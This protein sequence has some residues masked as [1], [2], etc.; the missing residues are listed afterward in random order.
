MGRITIADEKMM[1]LTRSPIENTKWRGGM[2]L[3][4]I[5]THNGEYYLIKIN[6]RIP[7]WVYLAVGAGQDIPEALVKL[8]LGKEVKP[9]HSCKTGKM[10]VCYSY[11][12][13]VDQEKFAAISMNR[14]I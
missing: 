8:A 10:F 2:E 14:E 3:E 11:D 13:L 6:P 4:L 7:A 1:H 5:M 9:M 12:L